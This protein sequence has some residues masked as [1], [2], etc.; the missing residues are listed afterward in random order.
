MT[1]RYPL[2]GNTIEEELETLSYYCCEKCK[3]DIQDHFLETCY[4]A[5]FRR[6]AILLRGSS[7]CDQILFCPWCG[8]KMP[9]TLHDMWHKEIANRG[10]N[11]D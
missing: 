9:G 4:I 7:G 6:Y 2:F 3:K 11:A 8:K 5:E 1:I 10:Y